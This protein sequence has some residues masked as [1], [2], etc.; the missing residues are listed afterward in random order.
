MGTLSVGFARYGGAGG[1]QLVADEIE[2]ELEGSIRVGATVDSVAGAQITLLGIVFNVDSGAEFEDD[3]ALELQTFG[4]ADIRAGDYLEVR[5]FDDNGTLVATRV[6]RQDPAGEVFLRGVAENV[7]NPTF[8]IL[9]VTVRTDGGTEFQDENEL[10][11]PAVTFFARAPGS[12]V[13]ATG[14]F[15]GGEILAEEVELEDD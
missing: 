5:A 2:Y 6:E 11:I 1:R 15:A 7:A 14:Q 4:L 3:S 8:T 9:S 12:V 13:E 10:L